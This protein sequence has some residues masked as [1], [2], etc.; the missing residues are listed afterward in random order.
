MKN[1]RKGVVLFPR[2]CRRSSHLGFREEEFDF[3]ERFS[4]LNPE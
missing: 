3:P 4:V 2:A 1:Q